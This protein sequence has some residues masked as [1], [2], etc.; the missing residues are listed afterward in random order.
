VGKDF[1]SWANETNSDS[2]VVRRNL[3]G[4][5]FRWTQVSD[6]R[7]NAAVGLAVET[8]ATRASCQSIGQPDFNV[9]VVDRRNDAGAVA[10]SGRKIQWPVGSGLPVDG[11]RGNLADLPAS[12]R[13]PES[14]GWARLGRAMVATGATRTHSP[15]GKADLTNLLKWYFE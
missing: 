4:K 2:V 10:N 9:G 15:T 13:P 8:Q 14:P 7:Q 5:M 11:V 12:T 1:T 3:S 6:A